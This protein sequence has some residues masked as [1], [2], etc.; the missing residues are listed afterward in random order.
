[1]I[2]ATANVLLRVYGDTAAVRLGQIW[3]RAQKGGSSAAAVP[4]Y[5]AYYN[6]VLMRD[7]PPLFAADQVV[8]S[9]TRAT[10]FIAMSAF[11]AAARTGHADRT[12][13]IVVGGKAAGDEPA[14][15]TALLR[16][17]YEAAGI[18]VPD[19]PDMKEHELARHV[20][21][22]LGVDDARIVS[23]PGDAST[24]TQ[25]NSAVLRRLGFDRPHARLQIHALAANGYRA[26]GTITRA[27]SERPALS[28]TNVF[29]Y[30]LDRSNWHLNDVARG[31][32]SLEAAKALPPP[33]GGKADYVRRGFMVPVDFVAVENRIEAANK[34]VVW[35]ARHD[36]QP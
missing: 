26:L 6:R 32:A 17:A 31:Y 13:Y 12:R 14:V 5:V 34:A 8:F 19:N 21:R 33:W 4:A 24:H 29:P 15:F 7:T 1:M 16:R 9:A 11:H 10:P 18:R 28:V 20:H 27:F 2:A 36:P 35:A 3:G 22:G 25:G 30:G 23:D